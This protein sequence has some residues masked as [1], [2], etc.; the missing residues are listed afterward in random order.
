[1]RPAV[2]PLRQEQ[3]GV[4]R[5]RLREAALELFAQRRYA[6]ASIDQIAAAAGDRGA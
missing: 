3:R 4:A 2:S 1:M 5:R 6:A